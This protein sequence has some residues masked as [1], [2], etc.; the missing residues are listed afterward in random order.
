MFSHLFHFTFER[1]CVLFHRL[2]VGISVPFIHI[3]LLSVLGGGGGGGTF[4]SIIITA[5]LNA[6]SHYLHFK[7]ILISGQVDE[8][9]LELLKEN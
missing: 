3:H 8:A 1:I 9:F 6:F 4:K 5:S 2:A 7:T